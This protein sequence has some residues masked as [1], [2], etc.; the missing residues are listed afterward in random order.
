MCK[1]CRYI[2]KQDTSFSPFRNGI[3]FAILGNSYS[4]VHEDPH[5]SLHRNDT[6]WSYI[7]LRDMGKADASQQGGVPQ[8]E[9]IEIWIKEL[10][11]RLA[12]AIVTGDNPSS[13]DLVKCSET[14]I[15]H[16]RPTLE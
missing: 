6:G 2:K 10:W 5:R 3:Q 9:V 16:A 15:E 8:D 4:G 1:L 12:K 14:T 7:Y 13:P 11:P